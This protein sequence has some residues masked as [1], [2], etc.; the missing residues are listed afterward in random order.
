MSKK[1]PKEAPAPPSLPRRPP[2]HRKPWDVCPEGIDIQL[3]EENV[4]TFSEKF[5]AF[6]VSWEWPNTSSSSQSPKED[7]RASRSSGKSVSSLVRSALERRKK[8]PNQEAQQVSLSQS[9]AAAAVTDEAKDLPPFPRGREDPN[10][11]H[12]A[13]YFKEWRRWMRDSATKDSDAAAGIPSESHD[14]RKSSRDSYN[15]ISPPALHAGGRGQSDAGPPGYD[16]WSG[17]NSKTASQRQMALNNRNNSSDTD[18]GSDY[19]STES[20]DRPPELPGP[21]QPN[22]ASKTTPYADNKIKKERILPTAHAAPERTH[23]SQWQLSNPQFPSIRR[24]TAPAPR[25]PR[26]PA[27]SATPAPD[28]QA[29]LPGIPSLQAKLPELRS[30]RSNYL[31][32]TQTDLKKREELPAIRSRETDLPKIK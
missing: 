10:A 11:S 30:R 4:K 27:D 23:P 9:V 17:T 31:P 19:P 8:K 32:T 6:P 29:K 18:N 24:S 21:N 22:Q 3:S 13:G 25:P 15:N 12:F 5:W 1:K 28:V 14:R 26:R 20:K 16:Q 7:A 2:V